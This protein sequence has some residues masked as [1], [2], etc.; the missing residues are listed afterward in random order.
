MA[1]WQVQQAKSRFSKLLKD[2]HCVGPQ[3]ITSHGTQ[4]AVVVSIEDFEK[5]YIQPMEPKVDLRDFLLNGP[6][7]FTDEEHDEIF[8]N[9]RDPND[10]GR[11]MDS[12][13]DEDEEDAA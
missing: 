12:I 2:S 4:T 7:L 5:N 10:T 6:K 1:A 9:L 3:Y 13:F 8:G 11:S